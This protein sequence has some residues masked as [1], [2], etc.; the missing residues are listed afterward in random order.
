M[1][2]PDKLLKLPLRGRKIPLL[3]IVFRLNSQCLAEDFS[4][5]KVI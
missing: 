2:Q 5:R 3:C 4:L 1:T